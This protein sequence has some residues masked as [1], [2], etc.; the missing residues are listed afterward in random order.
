M[1]AAKGVKGDGE[2]LEGDWKRFVCFRDSLKGFGV[3]IIKA[4]E[5]G[6]KTDDNDNNKW[7]HKSLYLMGLMP[8]SANGDIV[9]RRGGYQTKE[10]MGVG[11][12]DRWEDFGEGRDGKEW[13]I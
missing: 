9:G 12:A 1:R 4:S 11:D 3:D 6:D 10:K 13:S 2:G 5:E 8:K 7:C